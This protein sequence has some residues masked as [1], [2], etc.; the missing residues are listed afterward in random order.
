MIGSA[1][2]VEFDDAG[3]GHVEGGG[4]LFP[5]GAFFA[6]LRD[7]LGSPFDVAGDSF[8][9]GECLHAGNSTVYFIDTPPSRK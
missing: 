4:D 9:L 6:G 3:A 2:V 1:G 7:E 5:G 8:E